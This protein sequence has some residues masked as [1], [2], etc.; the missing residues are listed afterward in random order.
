MANQ[1]VKIKYNGPVGNHFVLSPNRLTRTYGMHTRGDE[2]AVFLQ[3][4]RSKPQIF[5]LVEEPSEARD[6]VPTEIV[7]PEPAE[8][9]H[10]LGALPVDPDAPVEP[11]EGLVEEVA[12]E[13]VKSVKP[14]KKAPAKK[15][16]A[17]K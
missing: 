3:D 1:L 4:Q 13:P 6:A 8:E 11:G 5:V 12:V 2:F 7:I 9:E 16:S 17:K 10:G 15:K 14:T